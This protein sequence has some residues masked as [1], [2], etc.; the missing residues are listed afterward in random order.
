MVWPLVAMAAVS[1][2]GTVVSANSAAAQNSNQEAWNRYN[3]QMGHNTNT[4]NIQSQ[5]MLGLFNASMQMKVAKTNAAAGV[6]L[7]E[8][9]ASQIQTAAIYNDLLLAEEERLLWEAHD[10]DQELMA[11]QRLRER[12]N[13]V[14]AQASSG[15]TIGE[16]SLKDVVVD[17]KAQEAMDAFVVRHSADIGAAKIRNARAQGAWQG[18]MQIQKIMYEGQLGSAMMVKNAQLAAMGQIMET[19]MSS[20]ANTTSAQ[21]ALASGMSGATQQASA[22]QATISSNLTQGLFSAAASGVSAYYGGKTVPL[23]SSSLSSYNSGISANS[24]RII[25]ASNSTNNLGSLMV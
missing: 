14:G 6:D 23:G 7:A 5:T 18:E 3:A 8:Y 21:H 10:L 19:A 25:Q 2:V 12:G 16:G 20:K 1:A 15:L 9:N 13:I 11:A 17:Q 24:S 22:N 4:A